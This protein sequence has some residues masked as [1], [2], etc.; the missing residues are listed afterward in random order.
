[1]IG[2]QCELNK[3]VISLVLANFSMYGRLFFEKVKGAGDRLMNKCPKCD[4]ELKEDQTIC[5]NC[6][7]ELNK[8]DIVKGSEEIN[9]AT[10]ETPVNDNIKW[11]DYQDV[12]LGSVMEHFS[13]LHEEDGEGDDSAESEESSILADYIRQHK[14]AHQ[15]EADEQA[16]TTVE[17]DGSESDD[18]E[19]AI[20]VEETAPVESDVQEEPE[21]ET[22][23][24]AS[25]EPVVVPFDTV[26]MVE[27][28]PVE[29][30][31]PVEELPETEKQTAPKSPKK[32]SKKTYFIAAAAAL[33]L[34]GG[35]WIYYDQ[36]QKAE[37]ARQ[38]QLRIEGAV[39][40]ID[41]DLD[42]FFLDEDQQFIVPGKTADE[43]AAVMAELENYSNEEA[44]EELV[45]KG[46]K[47]QV[48]I[49]VLDQLNSYFTEP[50][51][52]GDQLQENAH[53]KEDS[54]VDMALLSEEN[55]F[56]SLVNQAIE[57][58]KKES[59]Q[60]LATEK[61]VQSLLAGY[62]D[63]KLSDAVSRD[64]FENA[65]EEVESL[66]DSAEKEDFLAKISTV[67]NALNA[68]EA[69]QQAAAERAEQER[70]AAQRAAQ[71]NANQASSNSGSQT[72]SPSSNEGQEILSRN[73]PKNSN[74][75]PI[76]SS[77]QSD[78]NDANNP[79]W[80]WAPGVYDDVI[81]TS[82]ERGYIVEG[83]YKLERVR[84]ENGEGYYNLYA[85]NTKSS[86]MSG[87]S[88]SALPMYLFTINC[89]TGFFR[90]NGND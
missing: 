50:V 59:E 23:E 71:E 7:A 77:R 82:I 21:Q 90:G 12:P 74:N 56:S 51:I 42:A 30:V 84:I 4:F 38:E 60:L 81:R 8:E 66:F 73:T 5:P 24:E 46:Q 9:E 88:E 19:E 18:L 47:I 13:E 10:S 35:G 68:R 37:A 48:K 54:T 40:Q 39:A 89:K 3:K 64:D 41:S 17:Q 61:T 15:K 22:Q 78:I 72:A 34:A 36:Q 20:S 28:E 14:E 79:A 58:G 85:T 76:I 86:L 1:M 32:R 26:E 55:A 49:A 87:I 33:V 75:Q 80:N 70:A 62:Q 44:Y 45:A 11:S 25:E 52:V 83:G 6:G 63:N 2:F 43:I 27:S 29:T 69:E 53:I 65:K 31:T 67:E 16:E 57:Q